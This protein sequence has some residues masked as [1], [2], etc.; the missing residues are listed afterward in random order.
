MGFLAFCI[1]LTP[2][3]LFME[4]ADAS[5]LFFNLMLSF[6][7]HKWARQNYNLGLQFHVRVPCCTQNSPGDN[8]GKKRK[9]EEEEEE[10][11]GGRRFLA[12]SK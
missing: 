4:S 3:L 5:V 9:E 11:E 8:Y 1:V 2:Y 7:V 12:Y 10:E 6:K